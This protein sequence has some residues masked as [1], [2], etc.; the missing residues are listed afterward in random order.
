MIIPTDLDLKTPKKI[1]ALSRETKKNYYLGLLRS[2]LKSNREGITASQISR[3]LNALG[4]HYA[5]NSE[6]LNFYLTQL[7]G[8]REAYTVP[9]GNAIIFKY[10]GTHLHGDHNL[11]L[12]KENRAYHIIQIENPNLLGEKFYLIQEREKTSYNSEKVVGGIMI[13]Q[14]EMKEFLLALGALLQ[15]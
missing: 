12:E 14:A 9:V 2:I 7:V 8:M 4:Q 13:P 11:V 1:N 3:D 6:T 10:N 15:R 5:Y